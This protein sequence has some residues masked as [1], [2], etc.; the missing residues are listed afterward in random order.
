MKS[1]TPEEQDEIERLMSYLGDNE[2]E[3]YLKDL[4]KAFRG[5][6]RG[7]VAFHDLDRMLLNY[8]HIRGSKDHGDPI[9]VIADALAEGRLE[10]GQISDTLYNRIEIV[11]RLMKN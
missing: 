6:K 7:T 1:Y 4:E 11:V 3:V 2:R 9:L 5:W 10:R 8:S